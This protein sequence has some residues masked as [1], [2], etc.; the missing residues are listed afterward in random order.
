MLGS[1]TTGNEKSRRS[2]AKLTPF[3]FPTVGTSIYYLE[4]KLRISFKGT[5]LLEDENP[6]IVA[7]L[8]FSSFLC[9]N[10]L[11]EFEFSQRTLKESRVNR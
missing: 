1:D 9:N 5:V 11:Q 6:R 10:P 7:L 8:A 2:S 3:S 4:L